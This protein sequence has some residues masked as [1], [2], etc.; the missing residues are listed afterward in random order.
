MKL[1]AFG[2]AAVGKSI[3]LSTTVAGAAG[4]LVGHAGSVA[5]ISNSTL[6]PS[7]KPSCNPANNPGGMDPRP[8]LQRCV[9]SSR[10][11]PSR[12]RGLN[13]AADLDADP[14]TR[15]RHRRVHH[16]PPTV[17]EARRSRHRDDITRPARLRRSL[18]GGHF[19]PSHRGGAD[20]DRAVNAGAIIAP[21]NPSRKPPA[22]APETPPGGETDASTA[23]ALGA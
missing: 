1:F 3:L 17:P 12:R 5:P 16:H 23:H 7:A 20:A 13:P 18:P 2:G 21:V 19:D 8:S 22:P 15:A 6:N 9:P 10:W 11:N 14:G 4:G